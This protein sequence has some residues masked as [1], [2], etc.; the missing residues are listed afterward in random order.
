MV[1][2]VIIHGRLTK[3]PEIKHTQSGVTYATFTLAWSEKYKEVEKLCFIPC[4]AWRA[5][6][7]FIGKFFTKGKEAI[8]EGQIVQ[9]SWTDNEGNKKSMLQLEVEKMH[10]CGKKD[11]GETPNA[12]DVKPP[13]T[14]VPVDDE[15]LPF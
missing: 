1:N 12:T 8:A 7:E 13:E 10:F 15:P 4:K 6:A 5:T 3:D 11:A 2:H 14:F 9:Q